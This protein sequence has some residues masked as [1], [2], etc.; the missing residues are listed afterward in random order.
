MSKQ[1]RNRLRDTE[2]TLIVAREERDWGLGEKGEEIRRVYAV[3]IDSYR[4]VTEM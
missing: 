4:I 1:N 3:Q 2:N